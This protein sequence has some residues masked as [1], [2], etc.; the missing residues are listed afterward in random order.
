[1]SVNN[2]NPVVGYLTC[3][4]FRHTLTEAGSNRAIFQTYLNN[5]ENTLNLPTIQLDVIPEEDLVIQ[6]ASLSSTLGKVDNVAKQI[7]QLPESKVKKNVSNRKCQN[8]LQLKKDSSSCSGVITNKTNN[9]QI[10]KKS[11]QK[12]KNKIKKDEDDRILDEFIRTAA[13]EKEKLQNMS[14]PR[15]IN[16]RKD[17]EQAQQWLIQKISQVLPTPNDIPLLEELT[18][19]LLEFTTAPG[20][21][22]K[23][24]VFVTDHPQLIELEDTSNEYFDMYLNKYRNKTNEKKTVF[25]FNN[26]LKKQK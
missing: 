24:V 4:A 21:N 12:P 9:K 20:I 19:H 13:E 8:N 18:T 6:D 23:D 26:G 16:N 1:M 5:F 10:T 22:N 17:I 15:Q 3:K 2:N 25:I 14:F 11:N 7:L